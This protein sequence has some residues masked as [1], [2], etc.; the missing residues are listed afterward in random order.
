[1]SKYVSLALVLVL[2][3]FAVAQKPVAQLPT[4]YINTTWNQPVGGTTWAAPS[5]SSLSFWDR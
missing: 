5:K 2:C 1:M 4:T 3:G